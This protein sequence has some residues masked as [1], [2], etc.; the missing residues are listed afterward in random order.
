MMLATDHHAFLVVEATC[1]QP[2]LPKPSTDIKGEA[3]IPFSLIYFLFASHEICIIDTLIRSVFM[4]K[5]IQTEKFFLHSGHFSK[6]ALC[7]YYLKEKILILPKKKKKKSHLD[8]TRRFRVGIFQWLSVQRKG[9]WK[10]IAFYN[11]Y[12]QASFQSDH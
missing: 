4:T 5:T 11:S 10:S 2:S 8:H 6:R 9:Q 3:F 1:K 12:K 7:K